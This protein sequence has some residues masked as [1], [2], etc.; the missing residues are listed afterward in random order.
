[1]IL[2]L[3][4]ALAWSA[5]ATAQ[6]APAPA[7]SPRAARRPGSGA[8]TDF[9]A[10]LAGKH[11]AGRN[12]DFP[13]VMLPPTA[14]QTTSRGQTRHFVLAVKKESD[15]YRGLAETVR[16]LRELGLP[17]VEA[18][19]Q[20]TRDDAKY[21]A[22]LKELDDLVRS[23]F[24]EKLARLAQVPPE[25]AIV[26]EVAGLDN[27]AGVYKWEDVGDSDVPSASTSSLPQTPSL[28][29]QSTLQAAWDEVSV[30]RELVNAAL[31]RPPDLS[32]P[33]PE[34]GPSPRLTNERE[35]ES[36]NVAV[37]VYNAEL[38]RRRQY[39]VQR[40]EEDLRFVIERL[41]RFLAFEEQT[42]QATVIPR[43]D[44]AADTYQDI[45]GTAPAA[46]VRERARGDQAFVKRAFSSTSVFV[47]SFPSGALVNLD[48]AELGPT[49]IL[50]QELTV[51]ATLTL[52][53]SRLGFHDT[54][55]RE[56]VVARPTGMQR[57]DVVLDPEG[58]GPTRLMSEEQGAR[59][60]AAGFAPAKRFSLAAFASSERP[61][62]KG[63]KD[64]DGA[65]RA[66]AM[67]KAA[68]L[69]AGA[70]AYGGWFESSA[71]PDLAE[72]LFEIALPEPGAA[73][74]KHTRVFKVT[75]RGEQEEVVI[76]ET[77]SLLDSKASVGRQLSCIAE[78]LKQRRWKRAL[79]IDG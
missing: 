18:L 30:R 22:S 75:Y 46:Y 13:A 34:F 71:D 42:L 72:V 37:E 38:E 29:L 28:T 16:E 69:E 78:R 9:D 65:K 36:F 27:L 24:G 44:A 2:A 10:V 47:T 60:F 39:A 49:P 79:G 33:L 14:I 26:V 21:T 52:R 66:A 31:S 55:R 67:R 11:A 20:V 8:Q 57:V 61:G 41:E 68:A 62:Y 5:L 19:K 40:T 25:Q 70:A 54:E 59:L 17:K 15:Y 77:L 6:A 12:V 64:K 45:H 74:D 35:L 1:M 3:S 50:A 48:G 76:S 56:E 4:V 43:L 53:L 23:A 63:K 51:G 32:R 73:A 7:A 58:A